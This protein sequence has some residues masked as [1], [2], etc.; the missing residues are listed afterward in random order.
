MATMLLVPF[1]TLA[2][3]GTN[4]TEMHV[5]QPEMLE[6]QLGAAW[7]G[8]EFELKTDAGMYPGTISVGNDGVLRLEI[9]GSS[10]YILTCMNSDVSVPKP[11]KTQSLATTDSEIEDEKNQVEEEVTKELESL[12]VERKE[13]NKKIPVSNII[14]LGSSVVIIMGILFGMFYKKRQ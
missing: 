4:G 1:N 11:D 13:E 14:L 5:L 8:V 6:I 9:G 10:S 12:E 2:S 3:Q 7:S